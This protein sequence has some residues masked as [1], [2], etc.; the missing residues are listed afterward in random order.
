MLKTE[1]KK[2]GFSEKRQFLTRVS[3][4]NT[5]KEGKGKII[6]RIYCM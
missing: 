5:P 4:S 2:L 1:R 3:G 6:G